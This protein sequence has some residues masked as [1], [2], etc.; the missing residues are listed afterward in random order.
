MMR[1]YLIVFAS[2]SL[3]IVGFAAI[4]SYYFGRL[5]GDL[6]RIGSYSERDFGWTAKQP[7][8]DVMSNGQNVT[9]PDVLVLGDSFSAGNIWQSV[10]SKNTGY[11][12]QSFLY[13]NVGCLDNWFKFALAHDTARIIVVESVERNFLR[14]FRKNENCLNFTP[15]PFELLPKQTVETRA[16]E[17]PELYIWHSFETAFNTLKMHWAG[18]K[19]LAT[20]VINVPV[21]SSCA[22]LSNR[23]ADRLLYYPEDQSKLDWVPQDISTAV[24]NAL[25]M[26]RMARDHGKTLIFVL[27]PD[28][29]SV[30][31]QCILPGIEPNLARMPNTAELLRVAGADIPDLLEFFRAEMRRTTDLYFPN[32]THLSWAGYS[33]MA[34]QIT[35]KLPIRLLSEPK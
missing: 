26:Q 24:S 11:R 32:N 35:A 3:V 6:T 30:Y 5:D 12:T 25:A 31:G 9:Q 18:Q 28:K 7:V 13:D 22:N 20:K 4:L 34:R 2:I 16:S 21:V 23:R 29:L 19:R 33:L 27:V 15:L 14:R 17:P 10:V 1:R 8:L